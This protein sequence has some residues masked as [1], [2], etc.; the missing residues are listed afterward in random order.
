MYFSN[1]TPIQVKFC[2]YKTSSWAD[3]IPCEGGVAFMEPNAKRSWSP[4]PREHKESFDVRVFRP[5][6]FDQL[7]GRVAD[8]NRGGLVRI[9]QDSTG[10]HVELQNTLRYHN[11]EMPRPA[12]V[13]TVRGLDALKSQMAAVAAQNI[14]VRAVGGGYSFSDVAH[15]DGL[16]VYTHEMNKQLSLDPQVLKP[17][18]S[19]ENLRKVEGGIKVA[20]L[21]NALWAEGKALINQGGYD[22][23]T[24]FGALCT[25]TH[26]SGITLGS[27]ASS[28][29]SIHLVTFDQHWNLRDLQIE[30]TNGMT[31]PAAHRA[32]YPGVELIQNDDVFYATTVS[33]GA[34]GV[35]YSVTMEVRDAY[36][37]LEDRIKQSWN[38]TRAQLLGGLVR[39]RT[40]RHIEVL[41]NPYTGNT[42][43]TRRQEVVAAGPSGR[44]NFA[45]T[46]LAKF[47]ELAYMIQD[48]ANAHPEMVPLLVDLALDGTTDAGV[49]DKCFVLLNIGAANDFP[50]FS[51]EIGIDATDISNVVRAVED[52]NA[53]LKKRAS[54][55]KRYITSPYAL[56]FVKA[57]TSYLSMQYGR[58][59]CMIETPMLAAT[60]GGQD[61]LRQIRALLVQHY[62]GR[63]H[64]GQVMEIDATAV[65]RMYPKFEA[66]RATYRQLNVSGA[67]RSAMTQRCGLDG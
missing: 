21:N 27:I 34:M 19:P 62:A 55:D 39:D 30:P 7:L 6:F 40:F 49:V 17:G 37:L 50:V 43:L 12:M 66:F 13:A 48:A 16:F 46:D 38:D 10:F 3:N 44:R 63:P 45:Q 36:W 33:F 23:Q 28:V 35:V 65:T 25:G 5:A 57:D 8:V 26:G 64:W 14:V 67:F 42:V 18:V 2:V 22:Q 54:V 60:T 52:I 1:E 9:Y 58:D 31:D 4:A 15:T 47:K 59:T 41:V 20:T 24:L 51:S 61:T 56:R 29:R 32:T 11:I 53:T